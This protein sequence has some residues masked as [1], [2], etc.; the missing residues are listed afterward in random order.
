[1]S[2]EQ[3]Q[4]TNTETTHD[5]TPC[6]APQARQF[7]FWLG[8]WDLTWGED[9]RGTNRIEAIWDGCV[10]VENFDATPSA[11]FKGMSVSTYNA[12]L[13]QWQQ[14]WV[15]SNG[16]YLDF[17]GGLTGDKMILSRNTVIKGQKLKQRM[18][19]YNI[20]QNEM[21]WNWEK[22]EDEGETWRTL[23]HIHYRKK[24]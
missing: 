15:D 6:S 13:D 14:T 4:D 2:Q 9:G 21:D 17:V 24:A 5:E 22:S 12:D 3:S 23:W 20:G 11:S 16:G 19:W 7:D 18:V 10:I 1:M 8:E